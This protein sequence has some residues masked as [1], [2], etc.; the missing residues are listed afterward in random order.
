MMA[1]QDEPFIKLRVDDWLNSDKLKVCSASTHGVYISILCLMHKSD[2]YGKLLLKTKYRI[3]DTFVR[4]MAYQIHKQT[5]FTFMEVGLALKELIDEG[6]L[7][8]EG[9]FLV[10][11]RMIKDHRISNQ[12]SRAG[13][14]GGATTVEK[15]TAVKDEAA[16]KKKAPTRYEYAEH[17]HMT[18]DEHK[19]LTDKYGK[20]AVDWMIGKLSNYKGSKGA[21]YKSDYRAILSWVV[22]EAIKKKLVPE[23]DAEQPGNSSSRYQ[24]IGL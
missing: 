11:E 3:Y 22:D 23:R 15:I 8:Q 20:V 17:V 13:S 18:A 14:K 10:S 24:D 12:R 21:K 2:R 5:P 19:R 7:E 16:S 4:S 6:V 1:V 9:Y